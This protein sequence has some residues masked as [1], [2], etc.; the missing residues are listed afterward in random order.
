MA[1]VDSKG[2][3][4]IVKEKSFCFTFLLTPGSLV[5]YSC[6]SMEHTPDTCE[7]YVRLD[8]RITNPAYLAI[9]WRP[10]GGP[11]ETEEYL[12]NLT[13]TKERA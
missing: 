5:C 1:F 3:R 9:T 8:E 6:Y 13:Q 12:V 10:L 2:Q 4:D 11:P 7:I